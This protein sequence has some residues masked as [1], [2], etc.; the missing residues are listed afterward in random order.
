MDR[1]TAVLRSEGEPREQ[2]RRPG[3]SSRRGA[4]AARRGT[5]CLE[6]ERDRLEA[7]AAAVAKCQPHGGAEAE[8][9]KNSNTPYERCYTVNLRFRCSLLRLLSSPLHAP[10]VFLHAPHNSAIRL[11]TILWATGRRGAEPDPK[12][13]RRKGRTKFNTFLNKKLS[14]GARG[15]KPPGTSTSSSTSP[16][17]T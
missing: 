12:P 14:A 16:R 17:A 9:Y 2:A 10:R 6:G 7:A 15:P 11:V 4:R 1:A 13:S 8:T 3:A 5:A